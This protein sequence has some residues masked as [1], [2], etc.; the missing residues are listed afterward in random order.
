MGIEK[1]VKLFVGDSLIVYWALVQL[2]HPAAMVAPIVYW[3]FDTCYKVCNVRFFH[4][5]HKGNIPT[6]LL[7][8]Y[9]CDIVDFLVLMGESLFLRTSPSL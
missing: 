2:S 8:K 6:H 5:R 1:V 9:A 7:A 4:M 3:I